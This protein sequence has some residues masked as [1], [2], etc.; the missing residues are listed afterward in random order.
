MLILSNN[1]NINNSN[2]SIIEENTASPTE[3]DQIIENVP[4]IIAPQEENISPMEYIHSQD[5]QA[6]ID[7]LLNQIYLSF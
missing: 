7:V 2:N 6:K 3:S 5:F 4:K 1:N